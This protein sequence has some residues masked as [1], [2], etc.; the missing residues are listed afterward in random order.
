ME[1]NNPNE[2]W[3]HS[4]Y[5]PHQGDVNMRDRMKSGCL[6]IVIYLVAVMIVLA[7]CALFGSCTTTKYVAVPEHHTDTLRVTKYERDS[8]YMRDSIMVQQKGDT[9]TID[10]WHTLYRDR[11]HTDTVFQSKRDS[12]PYPVEVIKEVPAEL[13]WWQQTRLHIANILLMVLLII[14]IW[15]SASSLRRT[16]K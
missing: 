3:L 7:L 15:E 4:D 16:N 12:I 11:W 1:Y 13:T 10:R 14:A 8:I 5:I 2:P 9:L 6:Q